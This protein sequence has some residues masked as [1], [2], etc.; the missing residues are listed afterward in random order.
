MNPIRKLVARALL[1]LPE[2]WL[3]RMAGGSPVVA[4]G[5][6]LDPRIQFLAVQ[7]RRGPALPALE[8]GAARAASSSGLATL[9]APPRP[10]ERIEDR[11]IP[12]PAGPIPVRLYTPPGLEGPAPLL[13]YFHQGGFVIGDLSSCETFCTMLA[14]VGRCL[15]MSVDYRLAPEHPFPAAAEDALAAFAWACEHAGELAADPSR[16]AVAGDSAGGN[17]A[18]VVTHERKRAGATQPVFQILVYPWLSARADTPSREVFADS[19]PLDR[20]LLD[21]FVGHAFPDPADLD[22]RRAAP[23]LESDFAGLAPALIVTAGF[24]PLCDEGAAYAERLHAAGVA[25]TYRCCES[26]SHSFT[27]MSGLVPA[28]RRALES[29]A[30]DLRAAFWERRDDPV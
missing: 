26:L 22:D 30:E 11:A 13:L 3:V 6:R 4:L 23:L 25:V 29:I 15:V 27:A 28:A 10:M 8:P 16:I 20:P 24:D 18:A 5:R 17:L 21:W 7:A 19:W 1:G 2:A 12:G 9:D 14:E